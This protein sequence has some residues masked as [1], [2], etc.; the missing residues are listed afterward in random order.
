MSLFDVKRNPAICVLPWVHEF[1][2][3]SGKTGPCCQGDT[4]RQ[5][6]TIDS[7]R[8]QMLKGE[9]PRA[10][11]TCYTKEQ[12]S[13]YSPRLQETI[14]WLK[15][16]GEPDINR[17]QLQFLD[18]RFDPTC[19]LKC[20]TCGPELSTLWQKEKGVSWPMNSNNLSY[21]EQVDKKVLKKVYL[22]GGEPT[23]I[24]AYISFLEQLHE[25]NPECEV[26]I[27]SNLKKLSQKWRE[28]ITKL[29]NLTIVCSCDSIQTLGTYVRYP[30]R[31]QEFEDNVKFVSE[32]ADFLQFNLVASNLTSHRLFETSDWMVQYSKNINISILSRPA[33]FSER[34]VPHADRNVYIDNISKLRNFPV[35][36]HYALNFRKKISYL[37]DKYNDSAYDEQLHRQLQQE[38]TEQDGHRSLKL[39]DVDPFLQAWIYR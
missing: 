39:L 37:I 1:K 31:W 30:L 34:A 8:Q 13:G 26:I 7:I 15:K 10:C 19:N 32:H 6:E 18:V 3:I 21:L 28:I 38:I 20:K 17:P 27:N 4:L 24:K 23:Y 12:Q 9:M 36:V 22:A 35:G 29:K 14:D 25:I 33:L 16:F 2:T 11:Q 5:G